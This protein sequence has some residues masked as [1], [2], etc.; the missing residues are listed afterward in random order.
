MDGLLIAE[1]LLIA[2]LVLVAAIGL[3]RSWARGGDHARPR[4]LDGEEPT[5]LSVDLR[6]RDP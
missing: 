5:V 1:L 6:D 2:L 4:A 3:W